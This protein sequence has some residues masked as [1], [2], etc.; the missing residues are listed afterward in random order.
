MSFF[1]TESDV[2]SWVRS[3]YG[4]SVWWVEHAAGGTIGFPDAV[5]AIDGR[6]VF[7]ELK[8]SPVTIDG[9]WTPTLRASQKAVGK[10]MAE[11]GFKV[12]V[13]VGGKGTEYLWAIDI[14]SCISNDDSKEKK[15]LTAV[16]SV[17]CLNRIS[18]V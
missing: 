2:R 5:L 7:V 15:K 14:E 4:K 12:L 1:R 11:R 6:A 10:S 13:L 8:C 17:S 16:F 9:R 18:S 3:R